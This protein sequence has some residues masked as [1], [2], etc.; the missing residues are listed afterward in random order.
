LLRNEQPA[1]PFGFVAG[2]GC[3][4]WDSGAEVAELVL[5][6]AGSVGFG[7]GVGVA[8]GA[9]VTLLLGCTEGVALAPAGAAARF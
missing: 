7:V 1:Q 3:L 6:L 8:V 4:P 2:G 9:T 5:E